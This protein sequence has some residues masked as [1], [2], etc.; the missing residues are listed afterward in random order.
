MILEGFQNLGG[1]VEHPNPPRR[2]ATAE[3]S[4]FFQGKNHALK[5]MSCLLNDI[6]TS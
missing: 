6:L 1:G 2:Y 4:T 5:E 3:L